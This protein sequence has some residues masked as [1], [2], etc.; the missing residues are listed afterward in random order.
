[1]F[2]STF[3]RKFVVCLYLRYFKCGIIEFQSHV[4]D[5]HWLKTVMTVSRYSFSWKKN[6]PFWNFVITTTSYFK[7]YTSN[8]NQM[9]TVYTDSSKTF[10]P[11]LNYVSLE[12]KHYYILAFFALKLYTDLQTA[13][14]YSVENIHNLLLANTLQI[15][16]ELLNQNILTILKQHLLC[17]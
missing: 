12:A 8:I 1:M 3:I 11:N 4:T 15:N 10:S 9:T 13:I 14:V 2:A 17:S 7:A 5:M 16:K 6:F